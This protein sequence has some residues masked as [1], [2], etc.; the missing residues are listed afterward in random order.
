MSVNVPHFVIDRE[1]NITRDVKEFLLP[2]IN[3]LFKEI[4][5]SLICGML[6]EI[7]G[8]LY[9]DTFDTILPYYTKNN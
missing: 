6:V 5:R 3:A 7:K 1:Q 2:Y 4:L 8:T 9:M